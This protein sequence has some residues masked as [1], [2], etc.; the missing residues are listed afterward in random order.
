VIESESHEDSDDS[1]IQTSSKVF[2]WGSL[3]LTSGVENLSKTIGV[4]DNSRSLIASM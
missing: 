3:D 2:S 4:K 1:K